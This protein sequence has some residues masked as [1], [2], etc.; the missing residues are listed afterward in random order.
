M[1]RIITRKTYLIILL[2][3][4]SITALAALYLYTDLG[5][6]NHNYQA[7]KSFNR[8]FAARLVGDCETF[9]NYSTDEAKEMWTYRCVEENKASGDARPLRSYKVLNL[10]ISRNVAYVQTSLLRDLPLSIEKEASREDLSYVATYELENH[11]TFFRPLWKIKP[12][13]D[14]I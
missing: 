8:A 4:V 7:S 13:R 6:I 11:S 2:A 1:K 12:P 9:S 5:P 10:S 3:I 14:S